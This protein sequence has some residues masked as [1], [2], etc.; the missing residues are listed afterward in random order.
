MQ[1]TKQSLVS[2][3]TNISIAGLVDQH[4]LDHLGSQAEA[5]FRRMM[6]MGEATPNEPRSV[7][8]YE[9]TVLSLVGVRSEVQDLDSDAGN[10]N[11]TAAI[12]LAALRHFQMSVVAGDDLSYLEEIVS[13]KDLDAKAIDTL[14]EQIN[15]GEQL[16]DCSTGSDRSVAVVTSP[17]RLP[18]QQEE[19]ATPIIF[20]IAG[21]SGQMHYQTVCMAIEH[22]TRA[23][24]DILSLAAQSDEQMVFKRDTGFFVKLYE[25]FEYNLD[26]GASETIKEIVLWAHQAGYRMI[27]FD[28]DAQTTD[29]FPIYEEQIVD[30]APHSAQQAY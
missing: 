9:D 19:L 4:L 22:L 12:L 25:E 13:V 16:G 8:L 3:T 17:S 7:E 24:I 18:D 20:H 15:L 26:P 29:R 21:E 10:A 6:E 11:P 23:D 30:G 5:G 14:C 1:K 27:E 2:V 28:Q